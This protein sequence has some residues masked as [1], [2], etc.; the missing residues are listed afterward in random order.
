MIKPLKVILMP[1]AEEYLSKVE[2]KIQFKILNSIQKTETGFKAKYF[3]RILAF[4]DSENEEETL[5]LATHGFNKKTNKTPK[6]EIKRAESIKETY[7]L[8]K[9]KKKQ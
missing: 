4:W 1:E 6:S 2:Q 7:F 8:N 3:Y 5:I 9:K